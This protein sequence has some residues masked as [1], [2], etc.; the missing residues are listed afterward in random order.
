M[1][2]SFSYDLS[3]SESPSDAKARVRDA[4]KKQMRAAAKMKLASEDPSTLAFRPGLSWPLFVAASRVAGG[5]NVKLSFAPEGDGTQVAIS[6]KV[7]GKSANVVAS[8]EFWTE[9][10]GAT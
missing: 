8:R 3:L 9:T 10:L 4:V 1:A 7:S 6:G 5:E 2:Q